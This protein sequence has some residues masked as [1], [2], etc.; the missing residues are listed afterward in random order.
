MAQ[1]DTVE[2]G[3]GSGHLRKVLSRGNTGGAVV[4]GRDVGV[5]GANGAEARGNSCGF[6][7]TGDKVEGKKTE[8]RFV[9]EGCGKQSTSGSGDTTTPDLLGKEASDSGGMGSPT[10]HIRCMREGGG[11]RGRGKLRVPWCR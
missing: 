11:L 4:W 3:D 1:E 8:G 9:A 2:G 6:S 7:E 5:F 10:A